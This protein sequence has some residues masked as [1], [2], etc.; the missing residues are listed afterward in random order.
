MVTELIKTKKLKW[1]VVGL[2]RF[3]ENSFLPAIK[4]VRKSIVVSL[5]SRDLN[6][7]KELSQKFGV[8]NYFNNFDEFL[9]SDIDVVYVASA[10][11]FHYEQVIRAANAGKHIFCE[12]PLALNSQQ[13]EEMVEAAKKNNVQFAVNYVHHFHPLVLKAKE[14]LKDQ[15]LGKLVSVQVNFN[16]DFPPDN[17][18]RFKK[19]LSGGGALRDIGTHMIDLLRFF[20][21]EILEIDGV[22]DNLV[23]QSEVD[24]FASAIVKFE[25]GG[26]GYF[27]VSY[28]TRKA[29]NRIDILC[30]KGAI[31]IEN[32]IGRKLIGPKLSILFEGEARKSF[33]RRGN[34]MVF[35]LKSIQK[36]FMRNEK[37]LVTGEDGLINLKIMEELERKCQLK[38]K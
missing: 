14:L 38:N 25:K 5:C 12:K 3:V 37:P 24:D 21:G 2:G 19:E 36:S 7:A 15:K 31:E 33:R 16:I 34:K 11:A 28:N 20:G 30:H 18:F 10:N 23:Y 29:F 17:N 35:V 13:A 9:K 6:R 8:P 22:V 26:Y 27:N 32:L 1:G 4:S